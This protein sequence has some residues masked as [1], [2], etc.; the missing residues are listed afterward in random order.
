[1]TADEVKTA[2]E[3]DAEQ[4]RERI[5]STVGDLQARLNP[6]TLVNDAVSDA[7]ESIQ[8]RGRHMVDTARTT[9]REHPVAVSAV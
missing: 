6:R 8:D 2:M 1:M 9:V 4:A 5:A 3:N 7:V